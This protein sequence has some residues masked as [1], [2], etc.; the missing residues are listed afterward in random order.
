MLSIK[1]REIKTTVRKK[2]GSK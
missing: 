1:E 2:E